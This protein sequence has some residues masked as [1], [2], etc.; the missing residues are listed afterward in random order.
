MTLAYLDYLVKWF[1]DV[2]SAIGTW[3]GDVA[4]KVTHDPLWGGIAIAII[5]G[6]IVL[7]Y[8]KRKASN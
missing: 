5:V 6:I 4:H 3:V 1:T 7:I 2:F 8:L